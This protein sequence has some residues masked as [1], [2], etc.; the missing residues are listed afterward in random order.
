[1]HL[2]S[3]ILWL[4]VYP[5]LKLLEPGIQRW[6]N[7]TS[8]SL[9]LGTVADLTRERSELVL[10]NAF[11]RQQ[12]IVLSRDR[13]RLTLTNKDRRLLVLLARLLPSWKAALMIVQ[14]DTLIRWHV[15]PEWASV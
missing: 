2:I 13:K 1:M 7:P 5:I 15:R 6:V 14:P 9:M 11:L 4:F 12:V 3:R 8:Q 10:E